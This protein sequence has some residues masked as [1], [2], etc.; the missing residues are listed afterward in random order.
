MKKKILLLLSLGSIVVVNAQ[1]AA[2]VQDTIG[3]WT[4]KGNASLLFNQSTFDNW[5]AGGENNIS[6]TLGLNYDFNYKKED[7]SWDNKVIA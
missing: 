4:T 2:P 6:G 1:D 3:P 5:I 7:W